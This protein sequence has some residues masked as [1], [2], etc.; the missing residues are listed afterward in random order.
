MLSWAPEQGGKQREIVRQQYCFS[1]PRT[2]EEDEVYTVELDGVK[3]L[4]LTITPDQNDATA[5]AS[6]ARWQFA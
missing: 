3:T 1:P 4:Q 2:I 6:L 5:I